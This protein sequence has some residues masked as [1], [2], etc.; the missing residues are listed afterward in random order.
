VVSYNQQ[1]INPLVQ[2][3]PASNASGSFS[4]QGKLNET[5]QPATVAGTTNQPVIS[6]APTVN[7]GQVTKKNCISP[8]GTIIQHG[9]FVKAYKSSIGLIDLPCE[10]ELRLCIN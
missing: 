4:T 5:L 8:R 7:Q 9:Q 10:T 6:N 1:I 3:G 2:P